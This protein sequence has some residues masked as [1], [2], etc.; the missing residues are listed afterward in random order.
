[1]ALDAG[2]AAVLGAFIGAGATITGNFITHWA[3]HK[4]SNALLAKRQ[5]LLR[6]LL[7]DPDYQWRTIETL[8]ASIGAS[9]ETTAE[10]LIEM[11]ARTYESNRRAWGLISRN[12][13]SQ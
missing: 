4:R 7:E 11:G 6:R 8:S 13:F 2:W 9:E 1:M 12:P 5:A 3:N 10:I